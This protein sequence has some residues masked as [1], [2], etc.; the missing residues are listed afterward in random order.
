MNALVAGGGGAGAS[1][2]YDA[3]VLHDVATAIGA[4]GD[5]LASTASTLPGIGGTGE[6]GALVGLVLARCVE[7]AAALVFDARTTGQA[8]AAC[9]GTMTGTDEAVAAY[10]ARGAR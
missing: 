1:I 8:V 10:V 2:V 4:A 6:A 7:T 9:A 3:T 5:P